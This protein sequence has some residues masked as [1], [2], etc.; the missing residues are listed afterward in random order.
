[1]ECEAHIKELKPVD[2]LKDIGNSRFKYK[3]I[4]NASYLILIVTVLLYADG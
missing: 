3:S 4:L 2:S 1:M